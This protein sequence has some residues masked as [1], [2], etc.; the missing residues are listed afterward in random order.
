MDKPSKKTLERLYFR[1]RKSPEKIGL[2]YGKHGR[3]VRDWMYGY[4]IKLLGPTHL[5]TGKPAPWNKVKSEREQLRFRTV[6][7]GRIPHNKGKG[8][9]SFR[10][11]ACG[12]EVIDKPYRRKLTCSKACRDRMMT[13]ARG[14]NHWNYKDGGIASIQRERMWAKTTEWRKKV[15]ERDGFKCARCSATKRLVAHHLDGWAKHPELRHDP[16]NGVT[17]CHDCHWS[18]HRASSHKAA[19]RAMFERWIR[20]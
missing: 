6:N 17:L 7:I 2:I 11:K 18:F 1:E 9:I 13:E 14:E 16:D 20:M 8:N 5:T 10:C 15:L 12:V 3:T 4:G 19:T